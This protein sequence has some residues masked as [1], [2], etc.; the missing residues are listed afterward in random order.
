MSLN[1]NTFARPTGFRRLNLDMLAIR[2]RADK[3]TGVPRGTAKPMTYLAA[4]QEAEPYLGLPSH[5]F[6]LI[7]WL[8]KQTMPVDWEEGS[9]PIAWPSARRQQ[10]FLNLSAA[11]VKALNR[12]LYEAGI[13]VLRDNPQGKRYGRRDPAGRI[14]EAFGFD[15]SPLAERHAEFVRLAAEA[16]TERNHMKELRGRITMA[17]RAIC[18]AGEML[19]ALGP[20]PEGW[21]QLEI[22]IAALTRAARRVD[23]SEE[24]TLA[25]SSAERLKA[26]AEQWVRAAAQPVNISPVGLVC[27]PH[28]TSTNLATNLT[29]TVIAAEKSSGAVASD[30]SN[31]QR[32]P[33]EPSP[34][35][36]PS[37]ERAYKVH[38]N[39]L[40]ELAPR[41]A[42][43]L[44][45]AA[46]SWRDVVDAAGSWLRHELGVSVSLWNEACRIMGRETAALALAMVST[47]PAEHFNITPGAYFGGMVRR[48]EKGELRLERSLWKLRNA[49]Y[50]KVDSR[51]LN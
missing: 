47:K 43:H 33:S 21:R 22:D 27:E 32:L 4:F 31:P 19:E 24:M 36:K 26:E 41:L 11:R 9:R 18:Q 38:V 49:K 15:L 13:F 2:D 39:E 1:T 7:S 17:R 6:K 29:D 30:D 45:G 12:A 3:F 50:G 10:E 46:P 14:I 42:Q 34:P 35:S 51:R 5:A 40:C 44:V 16:R 20:M 28:N 8:V 25:A 37:A 48:A 23:R